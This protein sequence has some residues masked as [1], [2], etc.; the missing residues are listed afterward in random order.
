MSSVSQLARP[1][2]LIYTHSLL[3]P[4]MTFIL[5][6]GEALAR[7]EAVYVG[8]HRS[9]PGLAVPQARS[10]AVNT[11]GLNGKIREYLFRRHGFA[12][13][14][15]KRLG[16][17]HPVLVHAHFGTSGPTGLTIAE[18]LGIPLIVTF[19]G[20]DA[21]MTPKEAA[22]SRRG[23]E[24]LKHRARLI[25]KCDCI[26]AVSNFIREKVLEQGFP[27]DKVLVHHNGIDTDYFK[28]ADLPREPLIVFVGRFVEKKGVDYLLQAARRLSA[29]NAAARIILIGDGPLRPTLEAMVRGTDLDVEFT[30]FLPLPEVKDWLN[31]AAV[32]AVPSVTASNGDSEGL[33][34]VVLEAQSMG[35]PVVATRHS[36]IPEG[37][38]DGKT[39]LLVA[40]RDSDGLA[41]SLALLLND[42]A[43]AK[44]FGTDARKFALS[45]FSIR[46][47]VE[48]LETIYENVWNES[49]NHGF[50]A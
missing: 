32:V 13:G 18:Q 3:D 47:Q 22:S 14:F 44:Q 9:N 50:G 19:H 17:R 5:S 1:R 45:N 37:V 41:E 33:P 46:N 16:R 23:R 34:T 30:G 24:Y 48:G 7:H 4:S 26:I 39:A 49:S 8:A 15:I 29:R 43:K 20:M 12:P 11:G 27:P 40:E 28:P 42:P 38:L 21:T 35:T 31:R 6:H 36:G 10:F 2:V 25:E